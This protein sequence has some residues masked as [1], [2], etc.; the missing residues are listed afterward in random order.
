VLG[1]DRLVGGLPGMP[2]TG[3]WRAS[4]SSALH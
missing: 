1:E 2:G 3:G 4:I